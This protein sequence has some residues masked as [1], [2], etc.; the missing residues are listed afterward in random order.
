MTARV[1]VPEL[2]ITA[3]NGSPPQCALEQAPDVLFCTCLAASPFFHFQM[4]LLKL[5][6]LKIS[7]V[8]ISI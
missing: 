5:L 3:V 1:R 8:F 2:M 4:F 6:Q 7:C